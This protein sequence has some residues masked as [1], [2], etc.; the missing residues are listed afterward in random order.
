MNLTP[1]QKQQL[2]EF[3]RAGCQGLVASLNQQG[4]LPEVA[5]VSAK[6]LALIELLNQPTE[7]P[8]P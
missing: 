3:V 7:E 4:K 8:K 5:E 2:T 6:A 1:E